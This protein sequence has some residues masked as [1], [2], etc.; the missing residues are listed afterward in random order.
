MLNCKDDV[1]EMTKHLVSINSI[2]NTHGETVIAHA[3]YSLL[4]SHL[5]FSENPEHLTIEQTTNDHLKRY[6][7]LACVKGTKKPSR[8]TV[9]LMGHIDTVGVEDFNKFHEE[10]FQPDEWMEILRE[11]AIPDTVK[12]QLKSD[13]WLFGRGVLDMKSGVSSNMYLLQYY[14]N[15]PEELTGNLVFIAECDEEDG[16]HG[17]LSAIKTLKEWQIEHNFEYVAAINA[18]FVAPRYEGDPNRYIYSGTAGKLLPTFFIT[19]TETHVGA[20]FEGIDP[21]YIAAELT[22]QINYNPDLCDWSQGEVTAPPV[23]LKQTDLKATY[24]AQTALSSLAYYN[25]FIHSWSPK[26]VLKKLKGEAEVA[27]RQAVREYDARYKL[28]CEMTGATYKPIQLETRIWDYEEMERFLTH[29]YGSEYTSHMD[30]F[31]QNLLNDTSLD[32]RMFATKVVEEVWK[33]M[34]TKEPTIILFYSSLY[35]PRV[36]VSGKTA[37]ERKLLDALEKA[38]GT[39]QP[40]YEH[41]IVTKPF[42]PYISDMS[43]VAISDDEE[44]IRAVTS[45]NP[46]WE[47]KHQVAYEDVRDLNIPVINIG[48]YGMDAHSKLERMEITYSMEILPNLTKEVIDNVLNER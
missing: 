31:K 23:S 22:K 21:N 8:K 38:V 25:F 4:S 9:V 47:T 24:S 1:L 7:V 29:E 28:F 6:N 3:L 19:G 48:P 10:A 13:D 43:F 16:S 34:P 42:F 20:A 32:T 36:E 41:P 15:H 17:I 35:S 2:V 39:I 33:W 40:R 27:F 44:G 26:D 46:G 14:A 37:D 18:D 12:E 30:E 5:Y 45:N 11:E